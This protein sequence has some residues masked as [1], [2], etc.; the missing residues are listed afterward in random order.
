MVAVSEDQINMV[1]Y[2]LGLP[3]VM[4]DDLDGLERTALTIGLI[5]GCSDKVIRLLLDAGADIN[6]RQIL[7]LT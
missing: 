5:Y 1:S 2:L 3:G 6:H 4:V 7:I